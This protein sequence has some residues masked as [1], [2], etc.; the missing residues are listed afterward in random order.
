M[1]EMP[2]ING[3]PESPDTLDSLA[4][5]ALE[6]E[7]YIAA[8]EGASVLLEARLSA[9]SARLA[10]LRSAALAAGIPCSLGG[11]PAG[12]RETHAAT[13]GRGPGKAD[14]LSAPLRDDTYIDQRSGLLSKEVY[15]RLAREGA[16]PVTPI[17]KRILARWGDVRAALDARSITRTPKQIQVAE[18]DGLDDARL[19]MG[20]R[21]RGA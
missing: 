14:Q 20:L 21:P 7:A 5:A 4:R 15:L 11:T 9:V 2:S 12:C 1:G 17:G 10:G 8:A 16:F 13:S 19:A 6:C 3:T 18:G